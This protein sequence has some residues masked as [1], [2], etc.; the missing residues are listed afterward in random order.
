MLLPLRPPQPCE[1]LTRSCHRISR[2]VRDPAR[3]WNESVISPRASDFL[4]VVVGVGGGTNDNNIIDIRKVN[5]NHEDIGCNDDTA[6]IAFSHKLPCPEVVVWPVQ[7]VVH[8]QLSTPDAGER[9]ELPP[10][11]GVDSEAFPDTRAKDYDLLLPHLIDNPSEVRE[12]PALNS[13]AE[14]AKEEL[15]FWPSVRPSHGVV[16]PE[17]NKLADS[18]G[19]VTREQRGCHR[20][21]NCA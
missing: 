21:R 10:E 9:V 18:F 3:V 8:P 7:G 15:D 4:N 11:V 13:V 16:V 17:P 20:N 5:S 14:G 19:L 12:L 6:A 2:D 1:L